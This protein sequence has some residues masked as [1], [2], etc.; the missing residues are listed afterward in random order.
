MAIAS[1]SEAV[2]ALKIPLPFAIASIA[3]MAA[4][5]QASLWKAA[6]QFPPAAA[7]PSTAAVPTDATSGYI[8]TN[9]TNPVKTYL[10]SIDVIAAQIGQLILYDRLSANGG[11]SGTSTGT[12]TTNLP[13]AAINR[14][15]TTGLNVEGFLE[16]YGDTG[17]TAITITANYT[18]DAGNTGNTSGSISLAATRRAS[19]MF[20]IPRATGDAGIRAVASVA[21]S[22]S[23]GTAGNYG[24]TLCRR[25]ATIPIVA[26]NNPVKLGPLELG[27]PEIPDD[28]CLMWAFIPSSTSTGQFSGCITLAQG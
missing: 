9:P 1:L 27:L 16:W 19:M 6:G 4:G 3:N 28:C 14:G 21:P 8:F 25:L 22:A 5:I 12:V 26:A 17:S 23:T 15:D 24:I 2:T 7:T 11:I 20:P 13:T 10:Y 18:D